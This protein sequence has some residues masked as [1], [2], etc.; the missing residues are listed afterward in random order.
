MCE[1][2]ENDS[3]AFYYY[4]TLW[5]LFCQEDTDT[6]TIDVYVYIQWNG[7]LSWLLLLLSGKN[8]FLSHALAKYLPKSTMT[9]QND[10]YDI[11]YDAIAK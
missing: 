4:N 6:Y 3:M 9:E 11:M 2:N 7:L 1:W 5:W 10:A 8:V